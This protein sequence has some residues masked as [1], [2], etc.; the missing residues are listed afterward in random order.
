MKAE[1]DI[2]YDTGNNT[3]LD[4]I[5]RTLC[6][7]EKAFDRLTRKNY[8][9]ES[10]YPDIIIEIGASFIMLRKWM[11][12]YRAFSNSSAFIL[13]LVVSVENIG[14]LIGD[15]IPICTPE[16]GKRKEKHSRSDQEKKRILVSI[17]KMSENIAIKADSL[18]P[19]VSSV[20]IEIEKAI[21]P[22]FERHCL[23]WCSRERQYKDPISKRGL[24]T[25]VFPCADA[26]EYLDLIHDK[27]KFKRIVLAKQEFDHCRGHKAGCKCDQGYSLKGFR[28]PP[29]K[30]IMKGGVVKIFQIRM[31]LCK[32]CGER[33]SM[34]PS[35][36]PREKHFCIDIIGEIM[37]PVFL[38][39]S[40]IRAAFEISSLTGRKLKS[41]QTIMNWIKWFGF[42]HP[43]QIL[44]RAGI[45]GSGYFQEDEGF[46]KEPNLRTYT[47]A[48][49]DSKNM[50][51][52]HLDYVDHVDEKT[53]CESFE[54]FSERIDFKV[55]G[56]TKDKW[57]P[58]TKALKSVFKKIWIGFCHRHFLKK[59][60]QVLK[61]AQKQSGAS[62]AAFKEAYQ[63]IK[64]ILATA[65]SQLN[66]K[67]RIKNIQAPLLLIP[68][69][70]SVLDKL[71][72]NAVHY[73]VYKRRSGIK[74]TTSLV[75]NFL[76]I[77]K[78]K[79]RQSESFRDQ[80]STSFLL[81]A[82]ANA[83]NFVPFMSNAKNSNKSPFMLAQGAT[84]DLP[85]VQVM[86]MHNAFLF[87]DDINNE[88]PSS[89]QNL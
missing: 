29:R 87:V 81:R 44:T 28:S 77:I 55:L 37:R 72:E 85:W 68:S 57:V 65:N 84:Y 26:N 22:A 67:I 5:L 10:Q 18:K 8:Y 52:W 33:F 69:V 9:D 25:F 20:G 49:V 14:Q 47:V 71:V 75:D 82:I 48:M 34:L 74:K 24:K 62:D 61:E 1:K 83:R 46:E 32:C 35:F 45:V 86:N 15:L 2:N 16:N 63:S 73:S 11:S 39:G 27:E 88:N 13:Q 31:V 41:M 79:L 23:E 40:S 64:K 50:L 54:K 51:V 12:D 38:F 6:M 58:S 30:T 42:F 19:S 3:I 7:L 70:Q 53:L 76:K 36:L 56:V 78:R 21:P 66:I 4:N 59:L 17:R 80:R 43:A 89:G 60:W